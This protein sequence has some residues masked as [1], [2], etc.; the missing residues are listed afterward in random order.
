MTTTIATERVK[1]AADSP[2]LIGEWRALLETGVQSPSHVQ[3]PAWFFACL[4]AAKNAEGLI[5]VRRDA[6]GVVA[7]WPFIVCDSRAV[8]RFSVVRLAQ[9][10]V[11]TANAVTV[12]PIVRRSDDLDSVCRDF[13]AYLADAGC[14][15][16]FARFDAL[17]ATSP[18]NVCIGMGRGWSRGLSG[19][20]V[21]ARAENVYQ[22][23]LPGALT[24]FNAGLGKKRRYNLNRQVRRLSDAAES[25]ELRRISDPGQMPSFLDDLQSVF[26]KTWQAGT[27]GNFD[28]RSDGERRFFSRLSEAGLLRSYILML[29]SKPIA[30]MVGYQDRGVLQYAEIGYDPAYAQFSPGAVLNRLMFDDLYRRDTPAI[31]DFGYGRNQYKDLFSNRHIAAVNAIATVHTRWKLFFALQRALSAV[32]RWLRACIT[33]LH[34]D[35]AIRRA[36]KRPAT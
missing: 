27:Y 13:S 11:R 5:L 23:A 33:A 28:R 3:H 34:L 16:D 32:Y 1:A 36:L 10:P 7:I 20:V 19:T 8:L 9:R 22:C 21:S 24:E 26:S 6:S 4:E 17:P 15:Y 14:H 18:V 2:R 31:V 29:D 12:E 35:K 25:L 30:F